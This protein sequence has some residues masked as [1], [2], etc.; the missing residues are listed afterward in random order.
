VRESW[1]KVQRDQGPIV[2][3]DADPYTLSAMKRLHARALTKELSI[4]VLALA[5]FLGSVGAADETPSSL[6]PLELV[7]SSVAR[8]LAIVRARPA[9]SDER[10]T[11]MRRVA[12]ELFDFHEMSRR[13]LGQHWKGLSSPEQHEFVRLFTDVLDRAFVASVDGYT[14]EDVVF[15]GEEVKGAWA[16]VRSQAVTG[17]GVAISI[18]YRLFVGDSRWVAYDIVWDHVSLVSSYRSQFTSV[19]R[20]SSFAQLLERMRTEQPRRSG[21]ATHEAAVVPERLAAGLLLAV[22]TRHASTPR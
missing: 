9:G 17:R 10:R 6:G 1:T 7:K 3:L 20:T 18:D 13:A 19:I 15:L 2:T 21:R 4:V 14:S 16:Q 8:V 22:L 11:E 5:L 12:H